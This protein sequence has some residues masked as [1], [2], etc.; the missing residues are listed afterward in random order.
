[1]RGRPCVLLFAFNETEGVKEKW[2]FS[3]LCKI[4]RQGRE[5]WKCQASTFG[6]KQLTHVCVTLT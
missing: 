5:P 6:E 3:D 1:M 2:Q 4:T